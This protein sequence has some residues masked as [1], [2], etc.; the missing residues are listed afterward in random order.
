MVLSV[1]A[2]EDVLVEVV[3]PSVDIAVQAGDVFV[4]AATNA[5]IQT[6]AAHVA[7]CILIGAVCDLDDC[8]KVLGFGTAR[9]SQLDLTAALVHDAPVAGVGRVDAVSY[10][11]LTLPT[12][13]EV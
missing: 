11:H 1:Q 9:V 8:F 12:K 6:A 2:R 7:D 5:F 4:G 10:T 13:L 3:H